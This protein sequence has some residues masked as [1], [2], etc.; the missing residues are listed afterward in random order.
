MRIAC[1]EWW[2]LG[3]G[4]C[5]NTRSCC[6]SCLGMLVSDVRSIGILVNGV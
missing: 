2:C 5:I 6:R 1:N 4:G 3:L